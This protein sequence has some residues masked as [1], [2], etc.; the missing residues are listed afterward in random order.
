MCNVQIDMNIE[1]CASM[2]H[3]SQEN[4]ENALRTRYHEPLRTLY[5]ISVTSI[6][7]HTTHTFLLKKCEITLELSIQAQRPISECM[8]LS[9]PRSSVK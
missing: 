8:M 3:T 6:L 5:I 1:P 4:K 9:E 2:E 7:L